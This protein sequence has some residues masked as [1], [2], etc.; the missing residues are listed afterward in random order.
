MTEGRGLE[1][2]GM[3]ATDRSQTGL[4]REERMGFRVKLGNLRGMA[5][6]VERRTLSADNIKV[7]ECMM[8]RYEVGRRGRLI[9][10]SEVRWY[11]ADR[12]PNYDY[13]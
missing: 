6:V 2:L 8:S 12:I 10:S 5:A 11:G 1:A 3:V 7:V 4:R 9:G 13:V